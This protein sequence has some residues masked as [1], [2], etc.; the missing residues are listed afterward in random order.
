[1]RRREFIVLLGCAA[2]TWPSS[3][4]ARRRMRR[5]GLLMN[6][7]E[8]DPVMRRYLSAFEQPLRALGWIEHQNIHIDRRWTEGNPVLTQRYAPELVALSPDVILSLSSSNLAA[9]Q[10]KTHNVPIVFALVSDP[11]AQGFVSNLSHPGGNI[12]GFTAYDASMGGKWVELIKHL[13]PRLA[14]VGLL[15][16]PNVSI[17]SKEFLRSIEAA[18]GLLQIDAVSLP[19]HTVDQIEP[20]VAVFAQ[21]AGSGLIVPPDQFLSVHRQL[22]I[23]LVAQHRLP[24]IYA[25]FEFMSDGGLI[26]YGIDQADQVRKAAVY[27]DRI[28]KGT[29]P[30]DLP[31][32]NP[33]KFLSIINVKTARVLGI[34]V[35]FDFLMT[36][37]Q[38]IE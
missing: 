19:V 3:A 28:L 16:N 34:E 17:Q 31:V 15:F 35:P 9:L 21:H 37:D 26:S 18:A 29:K 27:V 32:Q 11:V 20:T 6:G 22:L 4:R 8:V 12:T 14:R 23:R 2:F 10:Q 33:T 30:G 38:V 1:M 36:A 13:V 5:L 24:A 7:S 25:Q